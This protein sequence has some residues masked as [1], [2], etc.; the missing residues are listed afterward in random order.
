MTANV[1]YFR[2]RWRLFTPSAPLAN[3][4]IYT[5]TITTGVQSISGKRTGGE[6]YLVVHYRDGGP[7]S[8]SINHIIFIGQ[9]NRSFD[10][11]FGALRQYWAQN[12]YP[13]QSFDGLPQFNSRNRSRATGRS[14]SDESRVQ[15]E[16][17]TAGRLRL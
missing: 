11:Y 9:E 13:D 6:L 5:A 12:G 16:P 7:V 15:C 8:T 10:H 14:G 2:K 3:N 1:T 17:T 4:T